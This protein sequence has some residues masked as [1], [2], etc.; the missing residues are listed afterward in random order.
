MNRSVI[1]QITKAGLS[2]KTIF[3]TYSL[4]IRSHYTLNKYFTKSRLKNIFQV[5]VI[6]ISDQVQVLTKH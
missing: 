5:K 2:R 6:A 3:Q 4:N 1:L